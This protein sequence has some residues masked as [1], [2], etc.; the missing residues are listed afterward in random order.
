VT[1]DLFFEHYSYFSRETLAFAL[2]RAGFLS[3]SIEHVFDGQYLWAAAR[4]DA[5]GQTRG[6]ERAREEVAAP[7]MLVARTLD[8]VRNFRHGYEDNV[9]RSRARVAGLPGKVAVW[10]AGAKGITF[11]NTVDPD[12]TLIDCVVDI[13]EKKQGSFVPVTAH[14]IV[15]PATATAR[16]ARSVVVMNP[17]YRSEIELHIAERGLS[18]ERV[19][20]A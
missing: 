19:V 20:N 3:P 14:P 11:V 6:E 9:A 8:A 4:L 16:G 10:G 5:H 2:R 15:A 13:N 18:F 12:A 7:D 17:N 1:Q